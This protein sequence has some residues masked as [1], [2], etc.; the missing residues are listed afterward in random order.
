MIKKC[1]WII[2]ISIKRTFFNSIQFIPFL[3]FFFFLFV[4]LFTIL[5][6]CFGPQHD[7]QS[8]YDCRP[9]LRIFTFMC[10]VGI[11]YAHFWGLLF[12][13]WN[14]INSKNKEDKFVLIFF[15]FAEFLDYGMQFYLCFINDSNVLIKH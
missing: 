2:F 13:G 4:W 10:I 15:L 5:Y 11:F 12:I 6:K 8:Q 3:S 14:K 9:D 1:Y 7:N